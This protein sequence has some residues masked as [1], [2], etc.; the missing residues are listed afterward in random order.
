MCAVVKVG[1]FSLCL[2]GG[3]DCC[4]GY[5]QGPTTENREPSGRC[6]VTAGI[7]KVKH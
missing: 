2:A 1:L 6:G 3:V 4:T 5:N 7:R